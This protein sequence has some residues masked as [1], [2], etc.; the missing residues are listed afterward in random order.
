MFKYLV[1]I[2][3]AFIIGIST[4]VFAQNKIYIAPETAV[5][6][7][8]TG[9]DEVLD[10]G[11]LA[12]DD[13]AVGSFLDLGANSRSSDYVFT[14]FVDQFET[15]PVVGESI[16]LYWA[17]GTDTANF[18]GVVTTAPGDSSTGTA[19]LAETPNL[20]YAGSAI[21]ITTTAASAKLRIS[22]FIRFLS[23]Y[24]FPVVHNN[25]ADALNRTGDGHSIILTPVPAEVQ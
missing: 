24:V 6:W 4:P 2:F 7:K 15:N 23:R 19:V 22:G 21:V 11:G 18:D 3:I 20:M 16:D 10:M 13:L 12:A 9:G 17:T 14:F 25:T 8:D 5:T 1:L